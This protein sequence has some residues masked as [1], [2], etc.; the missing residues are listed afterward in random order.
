MSP[1]WTDAR[2]LIR[3]GIVEMLAFHLYNQREH[4]IRWQEA[5]ASVR[6]LWREEAR[7]VYDEALMNFGV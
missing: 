6:V 7:R 3:V 4:L 5:D 1:L 2:V